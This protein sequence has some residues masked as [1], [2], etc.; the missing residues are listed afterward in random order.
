MGRG[1]GGSNNNDASQVKTVSERRRRNTR[2]SDKPEPDPSAPEPN[3]TRSRTRKKQF[4]GS[5]R[6]ERPKDD[7]ALRDAGQRR[8][9]KGKLTKLMREGLSDTGERPKRMSDR[10]DPE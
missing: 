2:K 9:R 10:R 3:D 4:G 6:D 7:A 1:S 5:P 8:Y